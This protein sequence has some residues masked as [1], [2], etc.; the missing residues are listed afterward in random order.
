MRHWPPVL[1]LLVYPASLLIL[2]GVSGRREPGILVTGAVL[3]LAAAGLSIYLALGRW[4]DRPRP[5][6]VYWA[7]G[8]LVGFYLVIAAAAAAAGPEYALAGVLAGV[9]PLTGL[10]LLIALTRSKTRESG[11]V[12]QDESA[13]RDQ[14]PYPGIGMDEATPLGDTPEHSD[15]YGEEDTTR[16]GRGSYR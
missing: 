6:M 11:G 1:W 13:V 2:V 10:C 12:L 5:P 3:A 15:A 9:I 7:L 14:D 16:P 8:G 4:D